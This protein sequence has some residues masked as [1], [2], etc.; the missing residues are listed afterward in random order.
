MA[1]TCFV[2]QDTC[3]NPKCGSDHVTGS[4][5]RSVKRDPS[6]RAERMTCLECGTDWTQTFH[7]TFTGI[8]YRGRYW[9][10]SGENYSVRKH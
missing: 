3:P 2:A 8:E 9:L 1:R 5:L 6:L 7:L 4:V 10:P